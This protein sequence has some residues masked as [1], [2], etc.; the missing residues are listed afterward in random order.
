MKNNLSPKITVLMPVYNGEKYLRE[1]IESI[2]CQTYTDFEFLI[3]NDGST[4]NSRKIIESYSDHRINLINNPTNI[5]LIKTLNK[6]LEIARG[7]Y[8][9][10]MDCDDISM[11][12]RFAKQ[13]AFMDDHKEVGLLGTSF[14]LIDSKGIYS[15]QYIVPLE[16]N[17]LCWSLCFYCPICHPSVM[18]RKDVVCSAGGY[19]AECVH[20]EDYELWYRL[21]KKS[22]IANLPDVLLCLRKH[23]VNISSTNFLT[24]TQNAKK[25][26]KL[27]IEDILGQ[28]V[29][30]HVVNCIRKN[31]YNSWEDQVCAVQLI[32]KIHKFFIVEKKVTAKEIELLNIDAG[33]RIL[34]IAIL[35]IF[36]VRSLFY[37][38]LAFRY[39]NLLLFHFIKFVFLRK[40]P[41][42]F[43]THSK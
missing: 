20:A 5:K 36:D 28:T 18:L 8:I 11:P 4:D 10:R 14:N 39:D 35:R 21:S 33:L 3:I 2:L 32:N 23:Q 19:D 37:I 12:E 15:G 38:F 24:H 30:N 7:E 43:N 40:F 17:L 1:A 26:N 9:A 27:I 6:G 34:I 16:H 42:F 25:I 13:V 29:D 22:I 31:K 41:S